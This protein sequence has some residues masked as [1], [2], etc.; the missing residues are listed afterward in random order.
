M[1]SFFNYIVLGSVILAS[2]LLIAGGCDS[3]DEEMETSKSGI[4]ET[5][6]EIQVG[7]DG[8]TIE[9]RNIKHR[10]EEDNKPGSIKY[11]YVVSAYS[12]DVLFATTVDG[13]VTSSGKRLTSSMQLMRGDRG[14]HYGDF[15]M[16]RIQDDG[17]HGS[18]IEYVYGWST[19][20]NY[21]Q[22]Y[23]AGGTFPIVSDK[24]L[25]FPKIIVN[26]IVEIGS[27]N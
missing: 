3:S 21:F 7:S 11:L 19:S 25:R 16:P 8:L 2:A 23:I 20:G 13:K 10:L 5:T 1:R 9:Q 4:R 18:S 6:A 15:V 27:N 14:N 26:N 17:T 22:F 24:P 12:G